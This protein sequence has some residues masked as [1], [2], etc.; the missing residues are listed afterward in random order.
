MWYLVS[1]G[2]TDKIVYLI[3]LGRLLFGF[4][5]SFDLLLTRGSESA[6]A[7]GGSKSREGEGGS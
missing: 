3:S 6:W 4:R 5:L 2:S 1:L 7:E